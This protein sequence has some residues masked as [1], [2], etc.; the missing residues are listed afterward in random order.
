MINALHEKWSKLVRS[1]P[2]LPDT[3][4]IWWLIG[5]NLTEK[6]RQIE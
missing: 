6:M 3:G 1:E 2:C 5:Q 4:K